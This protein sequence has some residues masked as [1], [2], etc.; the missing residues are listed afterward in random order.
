M[1]KNHR[2]KK[3]LKA[4]KAKVKLKQSKTKFLPKRLNVTNTNF[5]IKPIVL[6]EQLKLKDADVALSKRKLSVKDLLSRI[7]HYNE[8][9]SHGACE[10]LAE[11]IVIHSKEII[12]QHFSQ[13]ILNVSSLMQ[14]RERKVR[15]AAVKVVNAI[16]KIAP[17]TKLQPF[18]SYFTTNMRC[19]MTNIDKTIQEDSL[20]FLDCFLKYNC[21]LISQCSEKLLPD[22][23][24]LISTLRT[25]SNLERTLTM[26]LGSKMTSVTWRIKV[27]SRLHAVLEAILSSHIVVDKSEK[28]VSMYFNDDKDADTYNTFPIYKEAFSNVLNSGVN[29]FSNNQANNSGPDILN[30]HIITLVPL[31]YETWIEVV[32]EKKD[33]KSCY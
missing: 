15:K 23:F 4:E 12:N 7:K 25:D 32:P 13:I 24:T 9:V 16:L 28:N 17:E 20:L 22:F 19:A 31:L 8:N 6:I 14:D 26:N 18:F 33:W 5:K 3:D 29:S 10:E 11:M 2:H 27:L 30:R 21:R 1:G